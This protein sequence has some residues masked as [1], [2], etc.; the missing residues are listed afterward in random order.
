MHTLLNVSCASADILLI[1]EPWFDNI[2]G[3]HHGAP[4]HPDWQPILPVQPIPEDK[5]PQVMAYVRWRG[6]F[7]VTLRSDLARDLDMMY[8]EVQQGV[9]PSTIIGNIYNGKNGD[10][11]NEWTLDRFFTIQL[12]TN[13]SVILSGDWNAHH[14][15][16]EDA[17]NN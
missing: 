7:T 14:T 1:T 12:P 11:E 4:S 13:M 6:D 9:Y 8:L 5:H 3:E 16:W 17:A 10:N 2:G 15:L